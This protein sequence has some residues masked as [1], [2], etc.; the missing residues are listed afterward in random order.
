MTV[1]YLLRFVF[2]IYSCSWCYDNDLFIISSEQ[3]RPAY[4]LPWL[5]VG[6]KNV[7]KVKM[8][9]TSGHDVLIASIY[10]IV[11]ALEIELNSWWLGY[12]DHW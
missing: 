12:T 1:P 4:I 9:T 2:W 8:C 10:H 6:M 5:I 3:L 11:D 7:I